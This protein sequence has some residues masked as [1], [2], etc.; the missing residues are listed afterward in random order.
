MV[1]LGLRLVLVGYNAGIVANRWVLMGIRLVLLVIVRSR[2]IWT[3]MA[4]HVLV[5]M[6]YREVLV[7]HRSAL[8]EC[9]AVLWVYRGVLV[10]SRT[11]S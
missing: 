4:A 8:V 5:L 9:R 7:A 11:V 10:T 6:V 3:V 1:F 2:C